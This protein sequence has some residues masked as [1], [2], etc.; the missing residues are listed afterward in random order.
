VSVGRE[1]VKVE[2]VRVFSWSI[3]TWPETNRSD[4]TT[5]MCC[6]AEAGIYVELWKI[7]TTIQPLILFTP[8]V[9]LEWTHRCLNYLPPC[10]IHCL[11][12]RNKMSCIYWRNVL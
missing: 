7:G 2:D 10:S 12:Y 1:T 5:H 6:H 4:L 9:K 3:D 11:A 8:N